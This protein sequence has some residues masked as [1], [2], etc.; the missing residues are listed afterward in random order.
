[1]MV[2]SEGV[3]KLTMTV[4]PENLAVDVA[5]TIITVILLKKNSLDELF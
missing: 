2:Y 4:S 3:S 5:Q 1:M